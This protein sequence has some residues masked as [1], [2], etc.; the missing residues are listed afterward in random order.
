[1][2]DELASGDLDWIVV[3]P[4][5]LTQGKRRG[6]WRTAID[7]SLRGGAPAKRRGREGPRSPGSTVNASDSSAFSGGDSSLARFCHRWDALWHFPRMTQ[8]SRCDATLVAAGP[9]R[10]TMRPA[11]RIG[12]NT[13]LLFGLAI[14]GCGDS[15]SVPATDAPSPLPTSDAPPD[16][17]PP[18]V[19]TIETFETL[20]FMRYRTGSGPWQEPVD[21][22]KAFEMYVDADYEL[23]AVCGDATRGFDVGIEASTFEESGD[24]TFQPCFSPASISDP[25]TVTGTM[26]QPGRISFDDVATSTTP[27]WRFALE[28]EPGAHDLVAVGAEHVLIRRGIE[29]SAATTIPAIDTVADGAEVLTLPIVV[30]GLVGDDATRTRTFL[31]AGS[32]FEVLSDA[33]GT[34]AQL[35]PPAL[36]GVDDLQFVLVEASAPPR[37]RMA[38][39]QDAGGTPLEITLLPPLDDVQLG[40]HSA[41]WSTIPQGD[42]ELYLASASTA[43]HTTATSGWLGTRT[44]IAI[45]T[46]IPGFDP[47]WTVPAPELKSFQVIASAG[48]VSYRT[49]IEEVSLAPR[50]AVHRQR[51]LTLAALRAQRADRARRG[52]RSSRPKRVPTQLA[53]PHGS[54]YSPT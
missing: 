7:N 38:V 8:L 35:A 23:V 51:Q 2:E 20:A 32:S 46:D 10:A 30:N 16:A 50:I 4:G 1:M 6:R 37:R 5:L 12:T 29:I 41:T 33:P 18:N 17:R 44:A 15:R 34:T 52:V 31:F 54:W 11:P 21:T 40:A 28:L 39:I 48:E 36:V 45:D 43:V 24:A 27:N 53:Q 47:A 25:V 42:V 13:I 22:G 9:P 19:V 26:V 3:R 49:G 14:A